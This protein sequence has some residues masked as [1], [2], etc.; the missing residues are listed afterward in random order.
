MSWRGLACLDMFYVW[1]LGETFMEGALHV[2]VHIYVGNFRVW[3]LKGPVKGTTRTV[4][5]LSRHGG[6]TYHRWE[7][8]YWNL[9]WGKIGLMTNSYQIDRGYKMTRRWV[10]RCRLVYH[11]LHTIAL[12]GC[13]WNSPPCPNLSLLCLFSEFWV[14]LRDQTRKKPITNPFYKNYTFPP[15]I[16]FLGTSIESDA[17]EK[18]ESWISMI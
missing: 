10:R 2:N 14:N 5:G 6:L 1:I 13:M 15:K 16:F 8:I 11:C 18:L 7:G 17:Q 9:S 4:Q 12:K 3:L